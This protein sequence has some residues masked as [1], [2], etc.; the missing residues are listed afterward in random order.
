MTLY[1]SREVEEEEEEVSAATETDLEN[2]S[3]DCVSDTF[4]VLPLLFGDNCE[5]GDDGFQIAREFR[6]QEFVNLDDFVGGRRRDGDGCGSEFIVALLEE[7]L[8]AAN[9]NRRRRLRDLIAHGFGS[10]PRGSR[11]FGRENHVL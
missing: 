9:E 11:V 7:S 6:Q 10:E 5:I 8:E 3:A 4:G 1:K 2:P